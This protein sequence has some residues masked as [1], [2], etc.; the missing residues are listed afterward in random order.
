MIEVFNMMVYKGIIGKKLAKIV[1][2]NFNKPEIYSIN[3]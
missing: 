2:F 1:L 3:I